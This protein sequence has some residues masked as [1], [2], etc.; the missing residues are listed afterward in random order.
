[1]R[2]ACFLCVRSAEMATGASGRFFSVAKLGIIPAVSRNGEGQADRARGLRS[3]AGPVQG[4]CL[5]A[6]IIA[7]V[8]GPNGGACGGKPISFGAD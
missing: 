6:W 2:N 5:G 1:M 8:L 4:S 3:G 7:V